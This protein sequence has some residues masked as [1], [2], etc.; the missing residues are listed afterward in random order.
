MIRMS[1]LA[2]EG[3]TPVGVEPTSAALQAAAWP[4]GSGVVRGEG[5]W[6]SSPGVEPG[7]RPSHGRVRN[8]PHPE[9]MIFR[10]DRQ[11][12]PRDG[13]ANPDLESNQGP[14]LR[15]VQCNPLHHRDD[16]H[17][18]Q[19]RKDSNPVPRLWRPRALPGAR[20]YR[21]SQTGRGSAGARRRF[22]SPTHAAPL[23][24]VPAL[25]GVG[26]VDPGMVADAEALVPT[27]RTE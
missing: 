11:G 25:A 3:K 15:M 9:D 6:K 12:R 19:G 1:F 2:R 14:D 27:G 17:D 18:Q 22:R 4:S 16:G 24:E 8:P 7:L 13:V 21:D 26:R 20:P 23:Y 5:C 10:P